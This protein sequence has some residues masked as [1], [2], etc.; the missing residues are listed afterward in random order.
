M[1]YLEIGEA[2]RQEHPDESL[3][4]SR[5]FSLAVLLDFKLVFARTS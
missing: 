2:L 3:V 1:F 4:M 5:T